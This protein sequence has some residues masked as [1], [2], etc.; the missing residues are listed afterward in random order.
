MVHSLAH[1]SVLRCPHSS[2]GCPDS[3]SI[4][5]FLS[6]IA[7]LPAFAQALDGYLI[8]GLYTAA[9]LVLQGFFCLGE[10]SRLCER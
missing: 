1:R 8:P 10:C 9:N 5:G 7:A 4:A 6:S 2:L 3:R